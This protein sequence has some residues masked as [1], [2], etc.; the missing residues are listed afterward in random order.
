MRQQHIFLHDQDLGDNP[1]EYIYFCQI[2]GTQTNDSF[3][4][5]CAANDRD[6][7]Q[8]IPTTACCGGCGCE[9]LTSGV[10][11]FNALSG[12]A[13]CPVCFAAIAAIKEKGHV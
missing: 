9:L 4:A 6:E 12:D 5:E 11:G 1:L 3:C 10:G 2:C 13:L 7:S 8:L